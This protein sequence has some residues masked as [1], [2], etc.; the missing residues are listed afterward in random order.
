VA[1]RA[2]VEPF[3]KSSKLRPFME[4]ASM[5]SEKITL[6]LAPGLT[7]GAFIA[8]LTLIIAGAVASTTTVRNDGADLGLR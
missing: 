8:G 2:F 4:E 5:S 7:L 3:L 1:L 6:T